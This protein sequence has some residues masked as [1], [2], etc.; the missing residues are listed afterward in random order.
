[1]AS[2]SCFLISFLLSSLSV[3][4]PLLS[5]ASSSSSN[6]FILPLSS[7]SSLHPT[8]T[9]DLT[10][11]LTHFATLSLT[12]ARHIK[13][14][15]KRP[16]PSHSRIPLY[17]QGYGGYSI[18][19]SFG[20]P[21]QTKPFIMDTGSSLVWFPCTQTYQCKNCNF[22]GMPKGGVTPFLPKSSSSARILGCA[23]PKC[24]LIHLRTTPESRCKDCRPPFTNCNQI[25]PSYIII[26]GS[27]STGGLALVESLTLPGKKVPNFLVGCSVFSARQPAGIAGFG[28]GPTSLP[29]QL[30]LTRFSYCLVPHR[31]DD[32][33]KSSSLAME[34]GSVAGQRT[35]NLSRTPFLKNPQVAGRDPLSV[36]YYVNLRKISIGGVKVKIPHK[37]I[38]PDLRGNGGT[39]VDSGSSFTF[40]T[41]DVFEAVQGALV[42]EVKKTYPRAGELEKVTGLRPCFNISGHKTA[43]LPAMKFHFKGRA[44][45][46][47]PL[48]NYF[49]I[50][51]TD[52]VCL[53]MVTDDA[54]NGS[55]VGPSIILGNFQMQNFYVEYDLKND[56]FGFR[57]QL[58]K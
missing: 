31:F 12:R 8:P 19:L 34:T 45:M 17:P 9:P 54:V 50:V 26:Y 48:A 56:K 2:F 43:D 36:Y 33:G 41:H 37:H 39:I 4:F 49:S 18:P 10:E 30:G 42:K 32:T 51:A 6:T 27:G 57:Q 13:N 58:C 24:G 52:T 15:S 35:G 29:A 7:L 16:S 22:K 53:T 55:A 3:S 25:C 38:S 1:M 23:N 20:T 5:T 28:R 47:L 46:D 40:L 21:P 44:E 11:K 14:P